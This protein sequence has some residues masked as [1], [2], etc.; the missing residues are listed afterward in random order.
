MKVLP[1]TLGA[2]TLLLAGGGIAS[3][4]A[5]TTNGLPNL[6]LG[7]YAL[8]TQS[9]VC[10]GG[11]PTLAADGDSVTFSE[12]CEEG[13]AWWMVNLDGRDASPLDK[14]FLIA[15]VAVSV[16]PPSDLLA[17]ALDAHVQVLD[18]ALNVVA[19][20]LLTT[21]ELHSEVTFA[22]AAKGR[23]VR[24]WSNVRG[25][26]Q[27]SE[28]DIVGV[29][30]PT[31]LQNI[32]RGPDAAVSQ[33][34]TCSAGSRP[35]G[36][37][38]LAIDGVTEGVDGQYT[39]TCNNVTYPTGDYEWW[40]IDLDAATNV[41]QVITQ[42][43]VHNRQDQYLGSLSYSRVEVFDGDMN[44]LYSEKLP[45]GSK[46]P[47]WTIDFPAPLIGRYVRL[48]KY[49]AGHLAI[50]EVEV[51]MIDLDAATGIDQVITQINVHNR[52]DQYLGSLSYSRVEVF[53][54]DMNTLYSEK[55]PVGSK[56]P[57]WTIAFPTPLIGRFVR[58]R[59]YQAGHLAIA[60]VEVFGYPTQT[61]VARGLYAAVSQL[62]TCANGNDSPG[63]AERA[64]DG[65][66]DGSWGK[67]TYTC[68]DDG[69]EKNWW[70]VDLDSVTGA[71]QNI[72][73]V[74][75][76]GHLAIAEV[77]VLGYPTQTNVARGPYAA[78]SQLSTCAN[79]NDSLGV[80]ERA[81]DGDTDGSWGKYTYTCPDDGEEKNW[82]MVDLDSVTGAEQNITQVRVYNRVDG[83]L[84]SLSYSYL[85]VLDSD[86]NNVY[87]QK[88]PAGS[89]S[90]S[91][92]IDLSAIGRYVRIRKY[93]SG[94]LAIAE[95]QVIASPASTEPRGLLRTFPNAV[96]EQSTTCSNGADSPGIASRAIDGITG[97]ISPG[98][99]FTCSDDTEYQWWMVDLDSATGADFAVSQI[100]VHNRQD[101]YKS[102]LSYS[103]LEVLDSDMNAVYSEKLPT[104]SKSAYW[105]VD[106]DPAVVVGRYVRIRKY[107]LGNLA[108]AE[109][110][111][112]GTATGPSPGTTTTT[113]TASDPIT[114]TTTTTT[115]TQAVAGLLTRF[116]NAEASQ[117]STCLD[118]PASLAI[119]GDYLSGSG[120]LTCENETSVEWWMV[121][122]D[123]VTNVD[124]EITQ[125]TVYNVAQYKSRLSYSQV[126]VL[127]ANMN[128]LAFKD[129]PEG[130]KDPS[131][132]F[133]FDPP[134]VGKYVRIEMT[135]PGSLL[136]VAEVDVA[137][138]VAPVTTTTTTTPNPTCP[139]PFD[140][141]EGLQPAAQATLAAAMATLRSHMDA[142]PSNPILDQAQ[143]LS[144]CDDFIATSHQLTATYDLMEAALSLV[145][146]YEGIGG[147]G[148]P[149]TYGP[150]PLDGKE[151]SRE[152][153]AADGR[154]LDR[155]M[156]I[157][158]QH[159][160]DQMFH[161]SLWGEDGVPRVASSEM[162][163]WPYK[164]VIRDC[165]ELFRG[166]FWW[167]AKY[168]PGLVDPPADP[169]V[170][171]TEPVKADFPVHWGRPVA[172][173][174]LRRAI[175]P[176]GGLYLAPGGVAAITVPQE[177]VDHGNY[178]I[179]IGAQSVTCE[180]P[181]RG[182]SRQGR[183]TTSF[184][185]DDTTVYVANPFGGELYLR[186]PYGSTIGSADVQ[187]TGDV[188]EGAT[189]F[190]STFRNTTEAEWNYLRENAP[191][192][193]VHIVTNP[194]LRQWHA[195]P[196]KT[197][198]YEFMVERAR[199]YTDAY[200]AVSRVH[201][202][203][204]E[205]R[206]TWVLY[207]AFNTNQ[208]GR[209]SVGSM[210]YPQANDALKGSVDGPIW[211]SN[212]GF[213]VRDPVVGY[214]LCCGAAPTPHDHDPEGTETHGPTLLSFHELGHT[215]QYRYS[216][217]NGG[218]K[219][220]NVHLAYMAARLALEQQNDISAVDPTG[221]D[222]AFMLSCCRLQN[223]Y[224]WA[225]RFTIDRQ[226][227]EWMTRDNFLNGLAMTSDETKYQHRGHV[228]YADIAR[229]TGGSLSYM[230]DFMYQEHSRWE[231]EGLG[232]GVDGNNYWH[233]R[234]STK[235]FPE[236]EDAS[237]DCRTLR[238]SIAAGED[239]TPLLHF[240]GVRHENS[241]LLKE[242]HVARNLLPSQAQKDL[243]LKYK[244]LIPQDAA[245]L[246]VFRQEVW[247]P[248]I[249]NKC[250]GGC[251]ELLEKQAAWNQTVVSQ[252]ENAVD[253][254]I[255]MFWPS[256]RRQRSLGA[257]S[258]PEGGRL[259]G[260]RGGELSTMSFQP[261][262]HV[263]NL[264]ATTTLQ[265]NLGKW[266]SNAQGL[267]YAFTFERDCL[268]PEEYHGPFRV[269]V[270]NNRVVSAEY[271]RLP[272]EEPRL[273]SKNID[274]SKIPTVEDFFTFVDDSL[275]KPEDEVR[276]IYADAGY[277]IEIDVVRDSDDDNSAVDAQ[278]DDIEMITIYVSSVTIGEEY[279]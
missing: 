203:P 136:H 187:V 48:R 198:T 138:S 232:E 45:V 51:W 256:S 163:D 245:A 77:E 129:L 231:A 184:P 233:K 21:A 154:E 258:K 250:V 36:V 102:S 115:T 267:S 237:D 39:F 84:S 27:L 90:P 69:E 91:W 134:V 70:M 144:A 53:D 108:I 11:E 268:C 41:D 241:T 167:A 141:P 57:M 117:S 189:F 88:L 270:E 33:S 44:T 254:I 133:D 215:A 272:W 71:E 2:A 3:A 47:L 229:L 251:S 106:V 201:G 73:Q 52:Q 97:G 145:E 26:L 17:P 125:V 255:E 274:L 151:F 34:T 182:W 217:Y 263:R 12:T 156:I 269:L 226:A 1:A 96:A 214:G 113:T 32:A 179:Q 93:A 89:K 158:Q 143:I 235:F 234:S 25:S 161:A 5:S 95:V 211:Q 180:H 177:I 236:L 6:A 148:L 24:I 147:Y 150:P 157:V 72:T 164:P 76:Y 220:A 80:A 58:L 172:F 207:E 193:W 186:P 49:Q 181:N 59:K 266:T 173:T 103:Y 221:V 139:P 244:S 121:D 15:R 195:E 135:N 126:Q 105:I 202:I 183:M 22:R 114:T 35:P 10:G 50:A 87:L 253:D 190:Y 100:T 104:G 224:T 278:L 252:A 7:P 82:W 238:L 204:P 273:D 46:L 160:L 55:L 92:T 218:E 276:V 228:K 94:T 122:L 66:T 159:I 109:V 149:V 62:S 31:N 153:G 216:V 65:D 271:D 166:R 262:G 30:D 171:H 116:P 42:I 197:M 264:G 260:Q 265:A 240:W 200:D 279:V 188:V 14:N 16:P 196:V 28:V 101:G 37:A 23:Y 174:L 205:N 9:S 192:P 67:Y 168:V 124:Q 210:G 257:P 248:D 142:G 128:M 56:L 239:L 178:T 20:E 132:T 19:S 107:N 83:Y 227:I 111:V 259:R 110:E 40:M 79:G 127:D 170:V 81:V 112:V 130:S 60:E 152:R 4:T 86:M 261:A 194:L 74:R 208:C 137:G 123:A 162:I 247:V 155:T 275:Q 131:W 199:R 118:R 223:P 140:R 78:V 165:Q 246:D 63:V 68:P 75:V 185:V 213:E 29:E 219:E 230:D 222:T 43:N 8:T 13:S 146:A 169:T 277:P 243:L 99:T 225:P 206:N 119:D 18:D 54:G 175:Y 212:F 191:A 209:A 85:E 120:A 61:N 176:I 64:V 242:L 249:T 38:E 98:Y